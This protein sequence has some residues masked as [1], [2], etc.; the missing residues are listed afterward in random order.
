MKT[1]LRQI[2]IIQAVSI[3]I[4]NIRGLAG[5]AVAHHVN[6]VARLAFLKM[7]IT[8][9]AIPVKSLVGHYYPSALAKRAHAV[10]GG[11]DRCA[12]EL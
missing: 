10:E 12:N 9:E 7:M 6:R 1:M 3:F 2:S 5:T 8:D 4:V 11:N